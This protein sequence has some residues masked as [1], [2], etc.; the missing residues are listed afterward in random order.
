[1]IDSGGGLAGAARFRDRLRE[2]ARV[3]AVAPQPDRARSSFSIDSRRPSDEV[4]EHTLGGSWQSRAG[5]RS[6]LVTRRISGTVR[7]GRSTVGDLSVRLARSVGAAALLTGRSTAAPLVFFDLETT[8]LS[9][10]AGTYVFLVGCGWFDAAGGFITEQHLLVEPE[11]ERLMLQTVAEALARVG[12]LVSFNGKSFDVPVLDTRYLFHRL[13]PVCSTLPHLD[14]LHPARRFWGDGATAGPSQLSCSLTVL[15][16]Q[17]LGARRP[18]DVPGFQI[19]SLYFQFVRSGDVRLLISILEHNRR[20]LLSLAGLTSRLFHMLE[21]GPAEAASAREA[22][23][24]GRLYLRAGLD[25]RAREALKR[26]VGMSRAPQGVFDATR[27]EGLRALAL[28]WRRVRRFDEAAECWRQLI[29]TRGC[30]A[31][32]VREATEALAIHHEHRLRDL[33]GAKEFALRSLK[34][35]DSPTW[36]ESIRHRLDRIERKLEAVAPAAWLDLD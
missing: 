29:E 13:E 32:V 27:I 31:T 34:H 20:D 8:G 33:S 11:S 21:T 9:G 10:G 36:A 28:A 1:V 16:R 17:V 35:V 14:V 3:P 6:F 5:G 4:V 23:G 24:L 30:P 22:L 26:S 7:H 18:A 19:P 2:V 12:A 15:E 25:E